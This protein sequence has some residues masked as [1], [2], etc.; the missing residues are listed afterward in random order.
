MEEKIDLILAAQDVQEA[1]MKEIKSDIKSL[2]DD[3]AILPQIEAK[4]KVVQG[5]VTGVQQNVTANSLR[6][7]ELED[8][9][10]NLTTKN[11]ELETKLEK[12]GQGDTPP[13]PKTNVHPT[14]E[15][16]I[17]QHDRKK[18]VII[19]GVSE[20][21]AIP[22]ENLVKQIIFDT[23]VKVT[24][25]EIDQ[26][27]RVGMKSKHRPRAIVV[28][29][30]RQST[31]DNI[32][33]ARFTIKNNPAC[34][35]IWINESLDEGQRKERAE[36]RA[37]SEL[38]IREGQESRVVGD[39]LIIQGIKYYRN[40]LQKLPPNINLN[41]AYTIETED[42]IYFQSE[43]SW[44]SSFA[45]VQ[46]EYLGNNYSTLE[47]GYAHR[48]A[49]KSGDH[50]IANLIKK[51]HRPR[52]CKALTKKIKNLAWTEEDSK[53]EMTALVKKKYQLPYYRQKLIDTDGKRLVECTKDRK[54]AGGITLWSE[55]VKTNQKK[56]PGKNLLGEILE[57]ERDSILEKVER[58]QFFD[59]DTPPPALEGDDLREDE[60][61]DN[62]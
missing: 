3:V 19:E 12:L 50:E 5:E 2:K 53:T 31:R 38:A 60:G 54:W 44:P 46:I 13:P 37:L 43:H 26:V 52:K 36:L 49:V 14:L 56:L 57:K 39:T 23:G 11:A 40:D 27:Y 47:Q 32:Y 45:P 24:D 8:R 7:T 34:E 20:D 58:D 62:N 42:S 25:Q 61:I 29:F 10:T 18:Q 51:E 59:A 16:Q 48:M 22:L 21:Q 35:Q 55:S 28:S 33:R 15:E 4:L 41:R 30:L 1:D 9:I 6:L 17:R